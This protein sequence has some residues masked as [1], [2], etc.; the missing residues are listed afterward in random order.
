VNPL[1]PEPWWDRPDA[2]WIA[3]R[4]CNYVHLRETSPDERRAWVLRGPVV[5][6]GPD[7]EPL[8]WPAE[9]V[10]MLAE[11]VLDEARTCYE[12]EFEAGRDSRR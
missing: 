6:R 12:R 9:P 5:A 7:N 3:R 4:L 11:S 2:H 1:D 8:V 10:A